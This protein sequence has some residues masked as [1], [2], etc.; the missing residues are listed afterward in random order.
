MIR[1]IG[2]EKVPT[3]A[4]CYLINGDISDL[5]ND[6]IEM[7]DEWV[8]NYPHHGSLIFDVIDSEFFSPCPAFGKACT[9]SYVGL[10]DES[11]VTGDDAKR[12]L[13]EI[14]SSETDGEFPTH[15]GYA[16]YYSEIDA[17]G[18]ERWTAFENIGGDLNIEGVDSK[19][20]AI[21]YVSYFF[22]E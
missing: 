20:A 10:F 11:L 5:N 18:T 9:V 6:E 12:M 3:W 15:I 13:S 19:N 1:S 16:G 22:H 4:L 8:R 17:G 7:V 21:D 2:V 14:L